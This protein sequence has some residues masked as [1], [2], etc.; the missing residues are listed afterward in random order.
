MMIDLTVEVTPKAAA[1]AQGNE[2]KALT[3]H[4]G[5]HF[6][7]MEREFPLEYVIRTGLVLD[8]SQVSGRDIKS[9]DIELER[10]ERGRCVASSTGMLEQTEYETQG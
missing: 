7:A 10:V 2:K 1:D 3:G 8:D 4:L 6:D 5:T 9:E